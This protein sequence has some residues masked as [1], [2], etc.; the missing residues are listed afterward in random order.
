MARSVRL[1]P[2]VTVMD[3]LYGTPARASASGALMGRSRLGGG[4][5]GEGE[6]HAVEAFLTEGGFDQ[7]ARV[8]R[9]VQALTARIVR[10]AGDA[11]DRGA[12]V[13]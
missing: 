13:H 6:D 8:L 3:E 12:E 2:R 11:V 1:N 9:E 4:P 10:G 7:P 5:R